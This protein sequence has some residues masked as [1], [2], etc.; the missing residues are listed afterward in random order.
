M[1]LPQQVLALFVLALPIASI[2]W[3]MTH[4]E[5][6]REFRDYCVG[7]SKNCRRVYERKFFYLF[8]CEYCFSHWVTAGFLVLTQFRLLYQ[9]WRGFIIAEF[10]L[11]WVANVYMALF[12]RIRLD[13]RRNEPRSRLKKL[14]PIGQNSL[15]TRLTTLR[16]DQC[17][18]A[19]PESR[20]NLEIHLVQTYQTGRE[21][22]EQDG[23]RRTVNGQDGC[24]GR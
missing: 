2:A 5:V 4:E 10:A 16:H 1:S 12:G 21:S 24:D 15:I 9:D 17:N 18:V 8:T 3:T 13:L 11:V 20:R 22:G 14:R 19:L 7:R 23:F 6:L